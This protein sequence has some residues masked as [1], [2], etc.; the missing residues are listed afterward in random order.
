MRRPNEVRFYYVRSFF[1]R[2]FT[3]VFK[4]IKQSLSFI[5]RPFHEGIYSEF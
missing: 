2:I 3:K 1:N 5:H 4:I